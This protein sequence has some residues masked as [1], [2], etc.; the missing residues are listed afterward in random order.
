MLA[1]LF[2]VRLKHMLSYQQYLGGQQ[3]L[4][5]LIAKFA[6]F[7]LLFYIL[8]CIIIHGSATVNTETSE[9]KRSNVEF[10]IFGLAV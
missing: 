5:N 10:E 9:Q 8:V 3:H 6:Q 1:G 7:T 4:T 2:I